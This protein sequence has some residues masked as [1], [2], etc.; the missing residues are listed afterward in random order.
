MV[1]K[2]CVLAICLAALL[3]ACKKKTAPEK[4]EAQ[5]QVVAPAGVTQVPDTMPPVF[6][7]TEAVTVGEYLAFL[8]GT[9]QPVPQRFAAEEVGIGASLEGL[10]L[11]EAQR[12]ATWK[13]MR[14]PGAAE[15]TKAGKIVGDDPY[16]WGE[17]L[18]P[19]EPR[20]GARV[21]LVRDWAEGSEGEQSARQKKKTLLERLLL[22]QTE[23]LTQM[24]GKL[25]EASAVAGARLRDQWEQVKPNVFKALQQAKE[26]AELA[27][28][29]HLH[30]SVLAMLNKV[31]EE[32]KKLI[33]LKVRESTR[34]V[35]DEA[36]KQYGKF[37]ADLRKEIQTKKEALLKKNEQ[38]Q[39]KALELKKNLESVGQR[40]SDRLRA[41]VGAIAEEAAAKVD[42][43]QKALRLQ[44][45][46]EAN[47]DNIKQVEKA[48]QEVF[49][50]VA[51]GLAARVK[52]LEGRIEELHK[53]I[54][55]Q[56]DNVRTLQ[57]SIKKLSK[58]IEKQ[59]LDE[60]FLFND[61]EELTGVSV[62]K[63]ALEAEITEL[64]KTL[65]SYAQ[66]A[67]QPEAPPTELEEQPG[68]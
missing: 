12:Y 14:L 41:E 17:E 53:Q 16:P 3:T 49:R 2:L 1:R 62:R 26:H 30:E 11:N 15:W 23:K 19:D 7:S 55:E 40:S 57:D 25:L 8:Q 58:H 22:Q 45:R 48:S 36:G 4:P 9:G 18:G 33:N 35:M 43:M 54:N 10:T 28:R 52:D 13:M 24:R 37:L 68:E 34:E 20:K 65:E 31:G 5:R 47:E 59:F 61:L 32:K 46:L 60:S 63:S 21:F 67:E 66:P 64:E 42:S 51:E 56:Q 44:K 50:Q 38:L 6:I 39:A 27:A 29:E